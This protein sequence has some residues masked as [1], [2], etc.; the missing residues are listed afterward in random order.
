MADEHRVLDPVTQEELIVPEW[1]DDDA[2]IARAAARRDGLLRQIRFFTDYSAALPLWG[3]N[4]YGGEEEGLSA[5]LIRD[6]R[7]W[8]ARWE[9]A[10]DPFDG[11]RDAS[12]RDPWVVE[13]HLLADRVERELWTTAVVTREHDWV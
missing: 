3:S 12:L 11:W 13:G 9:R 1:S 7:D 4:G 8:V 10:F 5:A 2:T 6:L